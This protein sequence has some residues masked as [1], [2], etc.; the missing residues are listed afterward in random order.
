MARTGI[1]L[2]LD[3]VSDG[4]V[5]ITLDMIGAANR[6]EA[7]GLLGEK[8]RSPPLAVRVLSLDGK[9]VRT[10]NRRRLMVDGR[11]TLRSRTRGD[12]LVVPGLGLDT[13]GE[14][15]VAL[16][17]EPFQRALRFITRAEALGLTIAASCSATFLLAAAGVL[18]RGPATTT[19]WLAKDFARRFPAV[20]VRVD[21]MVVTH[22]RVISAGSAFAH[23][24]LMLAVL[25]RVSGPTLARLVARFLVADERPSQ[26]RYMIAQHLR[27]DDTAV[28]RAERYVRAHLDRAVTV[29][30]MARA[31]GTSSRTLARRM[32]EQC[33]TTPLRF[34]QRLR[35]E[36]AVEMLE[37]T[38]SSVEVIASKVGYADAAAFRRILRR[39]TGRSP[40]EFRA[41]RDR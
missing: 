7:L 2:V 28:R 40:R 15:D 41:A 39:E 37:T 21:S 30:E 38:A 32:K 33:E 26:A 1:L 19:W 4:A 27:A 10:S 34:V 8:R 16:R 23:A 24:D 12:V 6:I 31:A 5:G 36:R 18:D 17:S 9:P 14:I 11:A 3:G 22:R 29:E 20:E 35:A 25:S 13:P